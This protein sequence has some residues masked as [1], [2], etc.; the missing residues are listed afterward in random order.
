[1]FSVL[2]VG[3]PFPKEASW[4]AEQIQEKETGDACG[5]RTEGHS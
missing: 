2:F 1:M 3:E 4:K 5:M